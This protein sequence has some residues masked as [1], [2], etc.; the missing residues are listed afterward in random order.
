M[1]NRQEAADNLVKALAEQD[2]VGQKINALNSERD[3][4]KQ[5]YEEARNVLAESVGSNIR[6]KVYQ[7]GGR[8]VVVNYRDN[9]EASVDVVDIERS[10]E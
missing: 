10:T 9:G 4:A 6:T 5:R 2:E 3:V 7:A 8:A 1:N